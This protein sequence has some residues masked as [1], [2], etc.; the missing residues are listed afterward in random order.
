MNPMKVV[1]VHR[2]ARDGYQVARG[3]AE[4]GLL[5]ALVT[6]LYWPAD[7]AWARG[8]E[9]ITGKGVT[10]ALRCRYADHLPSKSVVRC[11]GSGLSSLL[12]SKARCLPFEWERQAVRWCDRSLGEKAGR[13]A[14]QRGAALLSYSYYG[15]SSFSHYHGDQPRILFQLHPHPARVRKI[16]RDERM[17]HPECASSLEKEWELALPEAEFNELV[18]EA[19]MA[20]YWLVA[21]T[22]TKQ[23]LIDEGIPA[24]RIATVPY[25][26]DLTR[27][28]PRHQPRDAGAPLR[29]LFVGTLS[30]RKGIKY[31]I[32]AME[33]LPAGAAELTVCGR[34][35]DDLELFRQSKVPIRLYPSISAEGL[36]EAYRSA[37]VF[38]FPSL[39][40]GFAQVLLE[41]MASG[42]PI[43]STRRT[44]AADL[45]RHGEE[46]FIIESG[47][48]SE[49]AMHIEKFLQDPGKSRLMGAA[50]RRRAEYFTW[51]RFR[52]GVAGY[53]EGVLSGSW[54]G[55][56]E[57]PCFQF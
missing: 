24:K 17:L 36:L 51:E 20:D 3:L 50:A 16:L 22:F 8:L 35:V 39:A 26:I 38:V 13:I 11:G 56:V 33:S 55:S 44:A 12:L 40:E 54:E 31:L 28:T 2:G 42:L 30:Q 23:T 29:L 49:L 7:R 41:A 45:I 52:Q 14:T 4:A 15:S 48:A 27:F 19:A 25:G 5:E 1:T 46:G 43:I 21:S 6:D 18:S 37:D 32:Q 34:A 53:V 10:E 57:E 47:S 9:R